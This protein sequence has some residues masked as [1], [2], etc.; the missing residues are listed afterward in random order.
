MASKVGGG[1]AQELSA[2]AVWHGRHRTAGV[3]EPPR[4]LGNFLTLESMATAVTTD[5]KYATAATPG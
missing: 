4:T 5:S 3:Y 2:A 1:G